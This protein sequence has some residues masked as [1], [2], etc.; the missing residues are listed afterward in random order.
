MEIEVNIG[1]SNRHIHLNQETYDLLFDE[2][3]NI[4]RPLH[5][6][7]EYVSDKTVTLI[8]AGHKIE[9]V[10][11]LGP[12]RAYNQV[13]IS[14]NDALKFKLNPPVRRSGDLENS[15][16]IIIRTEK[17]M[18]RVQGCI[19]AERHVHMTPDQARRMGISDGQSLK[20]R[21]NGLKKG[22]IEAFA[23]VSDNGYFEVHVDTDDA[24]A[25][26][27]NNDDKGTLIV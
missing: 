6:V 10:K 8:N 22:E 5:Q 2:P 25:F 27:L 23:K 11:L 15:E 3:I 1:V 13:E 12:L 9:N 24:N 26:I 7:G 4:L 18:I 20:V 19:I 14:H 17:A 21:F 16:Y